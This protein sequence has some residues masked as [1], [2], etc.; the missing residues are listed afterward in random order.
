MF[1]FG[2]TY[3]GFAGVLIVGVMGVVFALVY[4]WRKSLVA[5]IVMHALQDLLGIVI[6]P[7][8]LAH[9]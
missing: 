7:W 3:E 9:R 5:P 2:H 6:A 4:V 8:L 1:A